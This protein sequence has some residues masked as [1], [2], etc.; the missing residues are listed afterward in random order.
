MTTRKC[1]LATERNLVY[2]ILKVEIHVCFYEGIFPM[3]LC[4]VGLLCDNDHSVDVF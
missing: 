4:N 3:V 1:C 2:W